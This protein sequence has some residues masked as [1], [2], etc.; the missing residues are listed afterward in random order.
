MPAWLTGPHVHR[1]KGGVAPK[2]GYRRNI[3]KSTLLNL[4]TRA[5]I[6]AVAG[7][8]DIFRGDRLRWILMDEMAS[9]LWLKSSRD[10][11][12]LHATSKA[13]DS[14]LMISTPSGPIGAYFDV[15]HGESNV[16]KVQIRWNDNPTKNRGLYRMVRGVPVAVDPINNPLPPEYDPPNADVLSM[17]GRLRS[18]GFNLNKGLRSPWKDIQCLRPAETPQSEA[19]ELDLD[20]SGAMD[21]IFGESFRTAL[22]RTTRQPLVMG[23][24]SVDDTLE[25]WVFDHQDGGP[26]WLWCPL[27]HKNRPPGHDYLVAC[28]SAT[29]EGGDYCSNSVL[30]IIDLVTREQVGE[31]ASKNIGR[32]AFADFAIG[33]CKWF[34]G[35]YLAWEHGG[36]GTG[37]TKRVIKR[38]YTHCYKRP[39]NWKST[40]NKK[41]EE[42]GWV[43]GPETKPAA[44]DELKMVV[45][46]S[47]LI[48]RSIPLRQE[49]EQYVQK[50]DSEQHVAAK[51]KTHAD[52]VIAMAVA[53]QAMKDK[54]A[55]KLITNGNFN[56]GADIEPPEGTFAHML[57]METKRNAPKQPYTWDP[58][59]QADMARNYS[60]AG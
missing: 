42:L 56:P 54:P 26:F 16:I 46:S 38:G 7:G 19:R 1:I 10:Y 15:V 23:D 21:P 51:D 25:K 27:D 39:V 40:K 35:A 44:L 18:R 36:P 53:V 3:Q 8:P 29:G 49:A 52:R 57:W 47:D 37:F 13:T 41:T 30:T 48:V 24:F 12:S 2:F 43:A 14:R 45:I 33:V 59:R 34:Y 17:F 50:G 9:K 4:R 5:M 6:T 55:P 32:G 28:D 58:R 11:D 22:G 60:N 20:Y 31:Y